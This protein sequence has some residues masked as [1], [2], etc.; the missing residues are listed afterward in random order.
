A[1]ATAASGATSVVTP[2]RPTRNLRRPRQESAE[3]NA[4]P[5]ATATAPPAGV[6]VSPPPGSGVSLPAGMELIPGF[7]DT[8][9][10]HFMTALLQ[11][12]SDTQPGV[13][14]ASASVFA[15]AES[16]AFAVANNGGG[17]GPG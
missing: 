13:S 7:E 5:V 8:I 16:Q 12:G 1:A 3:S 17:G 11:R 2:R 9:D 4:P 6:P 15:P 10:S 14:S